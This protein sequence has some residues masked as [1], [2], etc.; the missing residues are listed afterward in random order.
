[1]AHGRHRKPGD[2][3]GA[4]V[5]TTGAL[6]LAAIAMA[7]GTANAATDAEWD[8]VTQREAS[9]DWGINWS[10]DG[11]SVGG[12][13]FQNPSWQDALKYL[14][15]QGID[16]SAFPQQLYQGMPN[17]P[18]RAQQMLAGEA[19]LKLQG[20]GAWANGNGGALSPSMFDGGP[21]PA[22]VADLL[23]GT[24]APADPAPVQPVPGDSH[25]SAQ[26]PDAPAKPKGACAHKTHTVEPGDTLYGITKAHT[27]NG[28]LD[29]WEAL[30][31]A[32]RDVVGGDPDVIFPGQVLTLPWS[33]E[34]PVAPSL[35]DAGEKPQAPAPVET[36][37]AGADYRSPLVDM[38]G[39]GD[40][41]F[42]GPGGSYSR[43]GGGH[44][45]VDFTAPTGT[46][47]RAAH[48]GT[49]TVGGAGDAYGNHVLINH[50]DGVWTLYAHLSAVNVSE[51]Q[52]VAAGDSIGA[53]GDTGNSSGPHLHF[54]VRTNGTQFNGFLDPVAWLTSHGIIN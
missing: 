42:A 6:S 18:T 19:L 8:G 48:G 13:Q 22:A 46:N 32:N 39:I 20:R 53:V 34:A 10:H 1:M 12:L 7:T 30:Y 38:S 45:G 14:R 23:G 49:V 28:A 41:Y 35:P 29:N 5:V 47:V 26:K 17:V 37:P 16:T 9:G 3:K 44:S 51:G 31:E 36:P 4:A 52:T 54:E 11:L 15:S 21:T 33:A 2:H 43:S 50:G 24:P 25:P 40:G 27:G